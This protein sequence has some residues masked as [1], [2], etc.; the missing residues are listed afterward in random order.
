[1]R[2]AIVD[3]EPEARALLQTYVDQVP[4]LQLVGLCQDAFQAMEVLRTNSVEL[5]FLDIQMPGLDGVGLMR[6]LANPP[7]VIFT[8]AFPNFALEGFELNAI[9]YLLKPFPFERFLKA[10]NKAHDRQGLDSPSFFQFKA[11]KRLYRVPVDQVLALEAV[12][13]Y[14]MI[15]LSD[16]KHLALGSLQSFIE[17]LPRIMTR[18]HRS[19]AVNL[20]KLE[21]MEGNFLRIGGR[22]VPIG[23]SYREMLRK[24]LEG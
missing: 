3:D 23:A 1:M 18:V 16:H 24:S 12:G 9:D 20:Q 15:Y 22:E 8:T 19:H 13:D 21:F 11:D 14:T 4:F 7:Q 17:Q 5:L 6:S 10:V 2:C